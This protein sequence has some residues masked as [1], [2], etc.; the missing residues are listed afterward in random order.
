MANGNGHDLER[1]L[2]NAFISALDSALT[3]WEKTGGSNPNTYDKA[4]VAFWEFCERV[5]R[6]QAYSYRIG[7]QL[8]C[9][10]L[11]KQYQPV[12][13]RPKGWQRARK[14]PHEWGVPR[15]L[16]SIILTGLA[17]WPHEAASRGVPIRGRTVAHFGRVLNRSAMRENCAR[18]Y[19]EWFEDMNTGIPLEGQEGQWLLPPQPTRVLRG[20]MRNVRIKD[21]VVDD[22]WKRAAASERFPD[23]MFTD[24]GDFES[25]A[26][27]LPTSQLT[28]LAN[29]CTHA[30]EAA[31]R[32]FAAAYAGRVRSMKRIIYAEV[33]LPGGHRILMSEVYTAEELKTADLD[34]RSLFDGL[35]IDPDRICW[36]MDSKCREVD[37]PDDKK[38]ALL[39]AVLVLIQDDGRRRLVKDIFFPE[40]KNGKKK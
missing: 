1:S 11:M 17:R 28:E 16:R 8:I 19:V 4:Q 34:T 39:Q 33:T 37:V 32:R 12:D 2:R 10:Y 36:E 6:Q 13:Q 25:Q 22:F 23:R 35:D 7:S 18:L 15:E 40:R 3:M 29:F 20:I 24:A 26:C 5:S 14:R 31:V 30:P 38:V 27:F 21:G 9:T